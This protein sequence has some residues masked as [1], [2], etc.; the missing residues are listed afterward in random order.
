MAKTSRSGRIIAG[1]FLILCG[2]LLLML[3][4]GIID[5]RITKLWPLFIMVPGLIFAAVALSSR[6]MRG[7]IFPATLFT[8]IG[9][10]FLLWANK[11]ID[12]FALTWPAFPGIVGLSFV[13]LFIFEPEEGL[14]VPA[15]VLL[16]VSGVAFAINY[17]LIGPDAW[18][19]WP[20]VLVVFGI[21]WIVRGFIHSGPKR[22][23]DNHDGDPS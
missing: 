5:Y 14:L 19:W 16:A 13:M 2:A 1:L 9:L 7:A 10:L 20:I 22:N 17:R 3:T 6:S 21:W 8:L 11:L 12:G 18:K 23:A 15:F 4:T